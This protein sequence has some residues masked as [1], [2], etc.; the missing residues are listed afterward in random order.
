MTGM[1]T[2]QS[3]CRGV[4]RRGAA[5]VRP[6]R[7]HACVRWRHIC[8][9]ARHAWL[10]VVCLAALFAFA[11]PAA[12]PAQAATA[13]PADT[14]GYPSWNMA[15]VWYPYSTTGTGYWCKDFDWGTTHNDP[16]ST[17]SRYGY[18]YR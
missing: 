17:T 5:L 18:S 3:H 12:A 14:G 13:N 4:V 6:R 2:P 15:C 1:R 8:C 10:A 11:V 16:N 7:D 9:Q